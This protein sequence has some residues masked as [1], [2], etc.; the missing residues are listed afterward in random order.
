MQEIQHIAPIVLHESEALGGECP[1]ATAIAASI[2]L[3]TANTKDP[4]NNYEL[5]GE[6][7]GCKL[8]KKVKISARNRTPIPRSPSPY[9]ILTELFLLRC[10]PVRL[11]D[12]I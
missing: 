4:C 9:P 6:M 10:K 5:N 11:N 7:V 12:A 2:L 1:S 8:V 3:V